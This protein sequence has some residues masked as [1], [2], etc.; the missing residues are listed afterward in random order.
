MIYCINSTRKHKN[1]ADFVCGFYGFGL[2]VGRH[3]HWHFGYGTYSQNSE[4]LT[5][6]SI[7]DEYP[8]SVFVSGWYGHKYGHRKHRVWPGIPTRTEQVAQTKCMWQQHFVQHSSDCKVAL[9]KKK[10]FLFRQSHVALPRLRPR[11]YYRYRDTKATASFFARPI[12]TL[13]HSSHPQTRK[14]NNI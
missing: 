8:V 12:E 14:T 10:I 6:V 9:A 7:N 11:T 5:P 13:C 3:W 1:L 2:G 4:L